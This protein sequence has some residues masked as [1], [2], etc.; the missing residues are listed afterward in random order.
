MRCKRERRTCHFGTLMELC[1]EKHSELPPEKLHELAFRVLRKTQNAVDPSDTRQW[2]P[3]SMSQ[4]KEMDGAI[5]MLQEAMD[6]VSR[7][8]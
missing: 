3:L 8:V 2:P 4:Q 1:H 5:V 7:R 6:Q